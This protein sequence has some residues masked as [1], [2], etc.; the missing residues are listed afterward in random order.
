M[1]ASVGPCPRLRRFLSGRSQDCQQG[2]NPMSE[3]P[4]SRSVFSVNHLP[5]RQRHEAWVESI[6][7]LY[8]V[9]IDSAVRRSEA[10]HASVS[11]ALIGPL[12]IGRTVSCRQRGRRTAATIA[13]DNK[14]H[15]MIHYYERGGMRR[16]DGTHDEDIPKGSLIVVDL[17]RTGHVESSDFSSVSLILP[18]RALGEAVL[19]LDDQHMRVLP[20]AAPLADVLKAHMR[21]IFGRLDDMTLSEAEALAPA[22]LALTAACLNGSVRA[23]PGA[24]QAL[25][26]HV[27]MAM[28]RVIEQELQNPA[29]GPEFLCKRFKISRAGLYRLFEPF[30]GVAGYIRERRLQRALRLLGSPDPRYRR[31]AAVCYSAGFSSEAEFSRCFKRRFGVRPSDVGRDTR[32]L[33]ALRARAS[34]ADGLDRSYEY[35][36]QTL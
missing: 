27:V 10:F 3:T 7:T 5:P 29:L 4:I 8:D 14:D 16:H 12:M 15:L 13:H 24:G 22:T 32:L 1:N 18:R 6:A 2:T 23:T 30:G 31:V 33:S 35:W 17:A 19:N 11:A 34:S 36:L 20:P 26:Q 21:T 28:R 25:A 9:D